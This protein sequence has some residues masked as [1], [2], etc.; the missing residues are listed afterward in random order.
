MFGC[1][2]C[3]QVQQEGP[4]IWYQSMETQSQVA[5]KRM[6]TMVE[7]LEYKMGLVQTEL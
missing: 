3:L 4:I 7:E 2:G 5:C 1:L 6:E